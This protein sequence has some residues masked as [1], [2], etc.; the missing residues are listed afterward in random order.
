MGNPSAVPDESGV[1][2][3][4]VGMY[5][6]QQILPNQAHHAGV[7]EGV[8]LEGDLS[9]LGLSHAMIILP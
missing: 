6:L 3:A 7:C 1:H 4:S 2:C 5:P 9:G 8:V